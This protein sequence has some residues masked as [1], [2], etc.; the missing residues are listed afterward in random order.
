MSFWRDK[1]VL[2][3]GGAGFVGSNLVELLVEEDAEVAVIDNLE[4]G[5]LE[6]LEPL[7]D[8]I[9][10]IRGDLRD[11]EVCQDACRGMDVVMNLA[12]K[13][14]G[15]EYNAK[16]SGTMFTSNVVISTNILEAARICDV[17]RILMVSSACVY[18]RYCTIPTPESEG[19]EGMPEPTNFGY[20]WAKRMAEIQAQCY[21]Q[22]FGMNIAIVRPYN[23]YGP[24]D[25]FD[26]AVSHVIP[27]LIKRI[28][29]GENPL[30]VWGD[31]EQTRAFVYVKD[32]V[33]G[34]MLTT[35]KY[36]EADA[37]NIGTDY[38]IKIKDLVRLIAELSGENPEICFDTSKPAGQPRRNADISRAKE[39]VRYQ[40]EVSLE[41]GLRL[42][43]DWY[44]ENVAIP[45]SYA[46]TQ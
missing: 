28:L 45:M 19:F 1:R 7:L 25:H 35:E 14:A 18:R 37:L 9:R 26:P 31:G 10:F 40:P 38:E 29:D 32:L 3:T 41:E 30:S 2:V 36:P 20:G 43:I 42:T 46:H 39:L 11:T 6:N 5:R 16:H 12:A 33:R 15:V 13:V 23:I 4:S 22:E 24:R 17:E 44:K 21:A 8:D 27:A 34:L